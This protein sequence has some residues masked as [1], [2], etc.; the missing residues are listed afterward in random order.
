MQQ[1]YDLVIVG[2][3]LA[4]NCLALALKDTGLR[5][6]IVEANTREQLYDSSAG[7]RAL[8]LAAG[9]VMML[10]ELD[11]W[12]GISHAAT[13]IKQIHISD[14]GHFGKTRL[15]AQKEGVDALGY[16]ISARD[17]ETYVADR[18]A[19]AGIEL[20]S[21]ARVVGMM[22]GDNAVCVSLK[23]GNDSINLSASL[24][25]GA[26]GGLS[27][28]RQLLD[29]TQQ[30]TEYGQTALVSMVKSTLPHKN[31]AFERFTASGPLALLPIAKNQCALVWTRTTEDANALML[32]SEADF[33]AELQQ[34]FGFKLGVLSLTAP[35]RAFP[36]SLIRADKMVAGR[37]VI[38]GNAVHQ[39]HPVAGQG[40]NLGLRDVVSLSGMLVKRHEQNKDMGDT[41]FL[42]NYALSRKKDHDL[43]I[44]FTDAVVKIFSNEWLALA[45]ARNIGLALLDHIPAAKTLLTRHAMGLVGQ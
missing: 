17:I 23:Q 5:M 16:V 13:P 21:P 42:N 44:G 39:L 4:G 18:V 33:L 45:L 43:T 31:T 30:T 24:L 35:R 41:D 19:N 34:C 38:I 15:S 26:D 29:I 10:N 2:G 8:A 27:S 22:S 28:V 40:F 14:Q 36:L 7:D 20:I 32:G 6:A 11:I 37:A 1:D 12:Q 9:T 3:G 25:V